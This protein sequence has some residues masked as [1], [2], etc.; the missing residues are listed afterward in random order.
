MMNAEGQGVGAWTLSAHHAYDPVGR[1]LYLGDGR[2]VAPAAFHMGVTTVAGTGVQDN[3]SGPPQGDGGPALEAS[4]SAPVDVAV[5]PDGSLYIAESNKPVIRRVDPDGV[6]SS[7]AGNGSLGFSEDGSVANQVSLAGSARAVAVG[8]DGTVYFSVMNRVRCVGPDGI[9]RT[10]AGTGEAGFSGD[11]G[12]A[13]EAQIGPTLL[14]IAAGPD[15]SVYIADN[16]NN[17]LRKVDNRGIIW[18]IAGTGELCHGYLDACGQ[19]E[20]ATQAK[21]SGP[22]DVALD[23]DGSIYI[24][25][26]GYGWIRR[27]TPEGIILDAVDHQAELR[28]FALG[29]DGNFYRA[30]T[31]YS[32]Y[33]TSQIERME[34]NNAHSVVVGTTSSGFNGD[35][36]PGPNTQLDF[37]SEMNGGCALD[38]YGDL[39]IADTNNHRIRKLSVLLPGFSEDELLVASPDGHEG[40]VFD[41]VGRHV[42][43]VDTLTGTALYEFEYNEDGLLST[44]T[45]GEGRVTTIE[46]DASGN[47]TAIIAPGGRIST[48]NVD[49]N[50]Y[51]SRI[52]NPANETRQFTYTTDGL[53]TGMTDA[54]GNTAE[55]TY[56]ELGLLATVTDALG[57]EQTLQRV[58]HATG[59]DVSHTSA[60]GL[61]TRYGFEQ[62]PGDT[63]RQTRE[64]ARGALSERVFNSD[65]TSSVVHSD[66]TTLENMLEPDPRFGVQVPF[67]AY[68]GVTSPAGLLNET[69]V[70]RTAT[71]EEAHNPLSVTMLTDV[72]TVNGRAYTRTYDAETGEVL[73]ETPAGRTVVTMLDDRNR[74]STRSLDPALDPIDITYDTEGRVQNIGHGALEYAYAYDS[75]DR[76]VSRTNAPGHQ[77]QFTYDAA[78]RPIALTLPSGRTYQYAYDANGNLV[79]ITMPSGDVHDFAYTAVNLES[80]YDPPGAGAYTWTHSLDREWLQAILPS[81]RSVDLLFDA[82]GRPSGMTYPEAAAVFD[83]DES[84]TGCCGAGERMAG[85]T[86]TPVGIGSAQAIAFDYDGPLMT[87]MIWSGAANGQFDYTYN[88]DFF[89]TALDLTSGTDAVNLA[90]TYDADGMP[91]AIGP[92]TITRDGPAR[93]LSALGDGTLAMSYAYSTTGR[94][95]DRTYSVAASTPYSLSLSFDNAGRIATR[96]ETAD[97]VSHT[98]AYAYDVD[99][100][101]TQVTR[102][103]AVVE[104]YA[105]DVN[106]NRV[107]T[108]SGAATYDGRDRLT[109]LAGTA[110]T[111][112]ADGYLTNRG[113]DTFVYS[114]RGGLLQ[115]TVGSDTITYS[116]DGLGRRVARSAAAGTHEYLFGNPRNAFQVTASRAPDGVLT[117]YYYDTTGVLVAFERGGSMFYVGTDQVGSPRVVA[118]STG[119]AVKIVEYDSFGSVL[120]DSAPSFDFPIGFAGG[121]SDPVTKL[122]R[123]GLRDYDPQSGR[124]T[125]SDPMLFVGSPFNLFTYVG[126]N[127]VNWRDPSG[128]ALTIG[129][130]AYGGTGGGAS[131]SIGFDGISICGE[132][133]F[134]L[135]GGVDLDLLGP[136]PGDGSTVAAEI[137]G[138]PLGGKVELNDAGQVQVEV[139]VAQ[140][141]SQLGLGTKFVWNSECGTKKAPTAKVG[142][143]DVLVGGVKPKIQ[144]KVYG[145]VC[146]GVTW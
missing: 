37:G 117:F 6:I 24:S 55:M 140:A 8:V 93:T 101:L 59:H 122:V 58:D 36:R 99:D 121:L 127:P 7:I 100:Q 60:L 52:T 83:Y 86:L 98:F 96:T 130:S 71:L 40:Y 64:N 63:I 34:P 126:N 19:G 136:R 80:S 72:V 115:A 13:T 141:L 92:F 4:V 113:T 21:L 125:A 31:Y 102:D 10:V 73:D 2:R 116:Y 66:G 43:T 123:F 47:P 49:A 54:L 135:G 124:W 20:L 69:T 146:G 74:P 70:S 104:Q 132:I 39:Y 14:G 50:G 15:G 38:P 1:V 28:R 42:R 79:R 139:G 108:L 145:Q 81:G 17:R 61:K 75:S 23:S 41:G 46:R 29:P 77:L 5:G 87:Q 22:V 56:T 35:G 67:V 62:D 107:S 119:T 112:D 118:D 138:G 84:G 144:G 134:G 110:Y 51:L 95:A 44:V 142:I 16:N 105:Y 109:N 32:F 90:A 128:V 143:A 3:W 94:I 9:L 85:V 11:G 12:P 48:L 78:D 65:S 18:T 89:L 88:D 131:I 82:F 33:N 76:L 25:G 30:R 26:A 27:I 133:G 103:S 120:S 106:G 114:A 111:F 53:M 68:Q 129:G 57:G 91:T 97:G 45:D 137:S